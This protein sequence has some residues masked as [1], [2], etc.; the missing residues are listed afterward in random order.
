MNLQ[1]IQQQAKRDI[2]INEANLDGTAIDVPMLHIKYLDMLTEC[3]LRCVQLKSEY[4][5]T[6]REKYLYY[7]NDFNVVLKNKAEIDV[8]LNG[9]GELNEKHLKLEYEKQCAAYL[10]SVVK[11]IGSLSFLIRDA[12]EWRKFQQGY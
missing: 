11:Q 10:E 12:I 7:R 5:T 3:Q 6:Y 2:K 8:M 1:H 9:D 4:D